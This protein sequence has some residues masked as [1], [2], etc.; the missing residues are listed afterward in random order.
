MAHGDDGALLREVAAG[1]ELRAVMLANGA[2]DLGL[3]V[4]H[5]L[6]RRGLAEVALSQKW[7]GCDDDIAEVDHVVSGVTVDMHLEAAQ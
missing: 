6:A 3:D 1:G 4:A 2:A 5:R 7:H